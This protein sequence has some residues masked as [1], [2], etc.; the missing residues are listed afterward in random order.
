MINY[1]NTLGKEINLIYKSADL[2]RIDFNIMGH[3]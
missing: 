2:Y 1:T 3:N